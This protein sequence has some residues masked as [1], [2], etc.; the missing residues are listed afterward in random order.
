[1][2]MVDFSSVT[3]TLLAADRLMLPP[4]PAQKAARGSSPSPNRD[5]GLT[6]ELNDIQ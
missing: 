6:H 3:A 2:T 5:R 1:M 4:A